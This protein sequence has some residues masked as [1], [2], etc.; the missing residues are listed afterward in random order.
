MTTG[1]IAGV[2]LSCSVFYAHH[3]WHGG[4][5]SGYEAVGLGFVTSLLDLSPHVIAAY[6]GNVF[7]RLIAP[8]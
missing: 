7:G 3:F 4:I 1:L 2:G 6:A 8:G 5:D